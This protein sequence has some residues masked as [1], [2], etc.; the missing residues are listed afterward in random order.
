MADSPNNQYNMNNK[1]SWNK[2]IYNCRRGNLCAARIW[3]IYY[4]NISYI[5]DR[6]YF[7]VKNNNVA[8]ALQN[9]IVNNH[10]NIVEWYCD[11]HLLDDRLLH[12]MLD[13]ACKAN[14]TSILKY[15]FKCYPAV[16]SNEYIQTL[17]RLSCLWGSYESAVL[18]ANINPLLLNYCNNE[19]FALVCEAPKRSVL[20]AEWLMKINPEIDICANNDY[21]Y[22]NSLKHLFVSSNIH[23]ACWYQSLKPFK[24]T[25]I[26]GCPNDYDDEW[27]RYAW[28]FY[29]T[30]AR[31]LFNNIL[32]PSQELLLY[33]LYVFRNKQYST[34]TNIIYNIIY[35]L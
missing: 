29:N 15:L 9:A 17:F 2:F 14:T 31:Y 25:G 10:I 23:F 13:A 3:Y 6:D 35:C 21:I 26:I 32:T 24:Y 27:D 8:K 33:L 28:N 12:C 4:N 5:Y 11:K 18:L 34:N 1:H 20:F 22:K 19:L 16:K 7:I 30:Y